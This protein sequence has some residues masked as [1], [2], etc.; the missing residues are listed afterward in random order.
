MPQL[1]L[2]AGPLAQLP[3]GTGFLH[4]WA[5]DSCDQPAFMVETP[6]VIAPV[7]KGLGCLSVQA[8]EVDTVCLRP[9]MA[10]ATRCARCACYLG[11][12]YSVALAI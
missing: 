7:A 8:L 3:P 5:Q 4:G 2:L 9:G 6:L 12:I 10:E 1:Q 11:P